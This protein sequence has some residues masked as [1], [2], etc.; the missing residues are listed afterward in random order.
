MIKQVA[1]VLALTIAIVG[2]AIA[3]FM[4]TRSLHW[5]FSYEA[6]V[7]NAIHDHVK[8]ECIK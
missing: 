8:Q 7:I 6:R 2:I 4:V 1:Q 3:M 5:K